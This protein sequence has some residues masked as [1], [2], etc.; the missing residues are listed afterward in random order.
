MDRGTKT[1]GILIVVVAI[2]MLVT[3]C[4]EPKV[5]TPFKSVNVSARLEPSSVQSGNSTLL[6]VDARNNGTEDFTGTFEIIPE[7][8]TVVIVE[9]R[10]LALPL[11]RQG[12]TA[13]EERYKVTGVTKTRSQD[14]LITVKFK[15]EATN[16]TVGT[17]AV[18]LNVHK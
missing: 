3:A 7:D 4:G 10:E 12:D 6:I 1:V 9:Q 15:D 8:P 11:L 18:V 5:V 16:A 17:T 13:G 14:V 2:A